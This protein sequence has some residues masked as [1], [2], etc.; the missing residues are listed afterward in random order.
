MIDFSEIDH[1]KQL[2]DQSAFSKALWLIDKLCTK[3]PH[4]P[5][6]WIMR[7]R[8]EMLEG[9]SDSNPFGDA[10]KFLLIAYQINPNDFEV[11][12]ELAHFYDVIKPNQENAV[13]FSSLL[14]SKVKNLEQDMKIMLE[15]F[16]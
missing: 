2:M 9:G 3:S 8:L 11:L 1:L 12:E 6:L 5:Y 10:E 15:S 13:K 14:L 4:S 16:D 7:A